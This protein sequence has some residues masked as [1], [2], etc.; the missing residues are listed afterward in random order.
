MAIAS[1]LERVRGVES[2]PLTLRAR[3]YLFVAAVVVVLLV[4]ATSLA[5][6][7]AV[8][9]KCAHGAQPVLVARDL[10]G[11]VTCAAPRIRVVTAP[12]TTRAGQ[13]GLVADQLS[14]DLQIRPSTVSALRRRVGRHRA[15]ALL[16]LA[17]RSW[18]THA[19]AARAHAAEVKSET[20]TPASGVAV[21]VSFGTTD[22]ESGGRL[23]FT[24]DAGIEASIDRK[25]LSD[26][27][28]K[29]DAPVPKDVT[30]GKLK[31]K[32]HFEDLPNACPSAAGLVDGK[33]KA[34]ATLQIVVQSTHGNTVVDLGGA[35]DVTY[36]V[37]VGEDA[38]WTSLENVD[39]QSTFSSG[40]S[41]LGTETWRSRIVGGGFGTT[42]ILKS[43]DATA[44][45]KD[46]SHL[47]PNQGGV[48]GPH[49]GVNWARGVSISDLR[50]I[51]NIEGLAKTN[52]AGNLLTLAALE[53]LRGVAIPRIEKHWYDD[54]ACLKIQA[55][56]AD[57][58]ISA[59]STTKVTAKEA[60]AADGGAVAA[61]LTGS[62]EASLTPASAQLP[63]GG[64]TDF[65]LTAP[66]STPV[67]ATWKIVALSHAGKKTLTGSLTDRRRYTVKLHSA[68][69]ANLATHDSTA[70]LTGVLDA[71]PNA[72]EP[73][74]WKGAGPVTWEAITWEPHIECEYATETVGGNW[75]VTITE[76]PGDTIQVA[77]E[78]DA[79]TQVLGSVTCPEA[80]TI[81]G[82]PG[83]R[84]VAVTPTTFTLPASGGTET[85]SGDVT[86]EGF[87]LSSAG[88]ITVEPAAG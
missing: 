73:Q 32:L 76:Q 85:I 67:H 51:P 84:L 77:W 18:R 8:R 25:G 78:A 43:H 59:G 7:S 66:V 26:L 36:K 9:K 27:A 41:H 10:K 48:F 63:L 13:L 2:S 54:E 11:G 44:I 80:A 79:A 23:G 12:A 71:T 65:T 83:P 61:S 49:G 35:I 62:G 47:D 16:A 52:L 6:K 45:S 19:G 39:V 58:R 20:F 72:T 22:V 64:T 33:L 28:G 70:T 15:D 53:Y 60:K 81:K 86:T 88:E 46:L 5:L 1:G 34:S 82:Q 17:L 56:A 42:S 75:N 74:T 4:P 38:H 87:H 24:A 68:E 30:G 21:T 55:M 14:S 40:G 29:A 37:K 3:A 57:A 31:L 69:V 50:S